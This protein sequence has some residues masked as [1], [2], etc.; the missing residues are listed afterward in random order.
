MPTNQ[1]FSALDA[2]VQEERKA[3]A[4]QQRRQRLYEEQQ[5]LVVAARS[6]RPLSGEERVSIPVLPTN[7]CCGRGTSCRGM[8]AARATRLGVVVCHPFPPIGGSMH[9]LHVL[10][11]VMPSLNPPRPLGAASLLLFPCAH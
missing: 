5:E 1:Q 6:Q 11:C 10:M 2:L 9:D 4:E 7:A 8:L 3:R